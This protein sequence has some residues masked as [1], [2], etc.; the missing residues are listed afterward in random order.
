MARPTPRPADDAP[1]PCGRAPF[2]RCCGP[3][4]A[5]AAPRTAEDLMRARF[6]AFALG[7]ADFVAATQ[8]APLTGALPAVRWVRLK[9]ERV[10]RGGADDATGQVEFRAFFL[11][12]RKRQ[13]LHEISRFARRDGRWIYLDAAPPGD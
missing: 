10:E 5:G 3:T 13:A 6:T 9:V 2:G 4:L 8:A 11:A 1:C 12:G 7:D